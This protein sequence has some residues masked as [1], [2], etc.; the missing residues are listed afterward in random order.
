M[1]MPSSKKKARIEAENEAK[2]RIE[3]ENEAKA[4]IEAE[5]EAK[6]RKVAEDARRM[7]ELKATTEENERQEYIE[8]LKLRLAKEV[9]ERREAE[10]ALQILSEKMTSLEY[11]Q[12]QAAEKLAGLNETKAGVNM[13]LGSDHSYDKARDELKEKEMEI[14]HLSSEKER[15]EKLYQVTLERQIATEE[16]LTGEASKLRLP[17]PLRNAINAFLY[18]LGLKT[19]EEVE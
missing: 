12:S 3:A 5:N 9:E 13:E 10:K 4:R 6:A 14:E 19:E 15:L 16:E 2:A 7:S 17:H 1:Q 11:A 8:N 18:L